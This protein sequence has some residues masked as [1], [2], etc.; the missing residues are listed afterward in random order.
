VRDLDGDVV[1]QGDVRGVGIVFEVGLV[2]GICGHFQVLAVGGAHAQA[3]SGGVGELAPADVRAVGRFAG[4]DVGVPEFC[5][6]AG[7]A[8]DGCAGVAVAVV[9]IGAASEPGPGGVFGAERAGHADAGEGGREFSILDFRFSIGRGWGGA[10][11]GR[12]RRVTVMV[13]SGWIVYSMRAVVL[14]AGMARS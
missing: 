9:F 13:A 4:C 11:A 3:A 10:A 2:E 8:A 6:G 5:H 1:A 14:P 12:R 7:V